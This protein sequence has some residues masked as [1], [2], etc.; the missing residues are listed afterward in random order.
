MA[1][2]SLTL[3]EATTAKRAASK[4]Y[5]AAFEAAKTLTPG[6]AEELCAAH[7]A[8]HLTVGVEYDVRAVASPAELLAYYEA[9]HDRISQYYK[10][11][12]TGEAMASI[13]FHAH[14]ER[15]RAYQKV[16]AARADLLSE[17]EREF[18]RDE[19]GAGH[20]QEAA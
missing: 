4:R 9:E 6:T 1:T 19:C 13:R 12:P 7:I 11:L 15:A 10:T 5:S 2:T 18:L 3:L 17:E 20:Y 14:N 8:L 16:Q